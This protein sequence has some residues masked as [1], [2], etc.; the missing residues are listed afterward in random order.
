MESPRTSPRDLWPA[1]EQF[2][3]REG[4]LRVGVAPLNDPT[5]EHFRGW[6]DR[7]FH[8]GMGYLKK[9]LAARE[10]PEER[11][12]W[13]RSILVL[14]V[15]YSPRRNAH[16]G[17]LGAHIARY[18]LGDDYHHTLDR[19]LRRLELLL[20]D[21]DPSIRTRRYVDTGPLSDRA[22]AQQAGLGW[23]GKN[24]MLIDPKAGSWFF[25]AT[26]L[27]SLEPEPVQA[28]ITDLCGSCTRCIDACPTEAIVEGRAVDSNRCISYLTIE[29]RG[30]IADSLK[31]RLD[32]NL[33]GC[34][35]CQEVCPWNHT[36]AGSHPA[37]E[38]RDEYARRPIHALLEMDQEAFSTL[39]RKSAVKRAKRVGMIRNALLVEPR[40]GSADRVRL[41]HE[42][43]AGIR[44]ALT[45]AHSD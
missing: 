33:F 21:L 11:F 34:D 23:I 35:I 15:P 41:S 45:G 19:M 31:D 27:T 22:A 9:N 40:I 20:E 42:E 29:H 28:E 16:E 5:I 39:F 26:L 36:P 4:A 44:D 37:F 25:I 13:A 18:A 38:P 10:T 17:S 8:A 30:P 24:G 43:D 2:A 12:P 3:G 32:G 14:T 7:G 6:L 1:L